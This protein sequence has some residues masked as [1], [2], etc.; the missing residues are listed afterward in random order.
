MLARMRKKKNAMAER[1]PAIDKNVAFREF[2]QTEDAA[3]IEAEIMT[4]RQRLKSTRQ[5]LAIMTETVNAVKR[6]IDEARGFLDMK[7]EE[8]NKNA[9]TQQLAPGFTS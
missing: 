8:K 7:T 6:E 2:K 4:C 3:N 9:L 1:R 5:E